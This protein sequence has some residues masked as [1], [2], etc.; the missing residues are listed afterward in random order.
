MGFIFRN[1]WKKMFYLFLFGTVSSVLLVLGVYIHFS[2]D[3]P[4][5]TG[6]ED[7]RP[8]QITKVYAEDGT[9]I[10]EFAKEK[11]IYTPISEIPKDVIAAYLAAED[12]SFYTHGGFDIKGIVR[13]ML[14]NIMT[15]KLQGASTITQQVAK[16]FLLSSERTYTRKIK[17]LILARRIESHFTKNQILELYLNQ[18]YLGNGTYGVAAA[19][20]GYFGKRLDEL[21]IGERAML[22]GLPKAP[23]S[24]NPY[25]RYERAI[26]RRNVVLMR[27][28]DENVITQEEY[29]TV[30][31]SDL[32]LAPRAG[33]SFPV[34]GF[35][36]EAVRRQV[37]DDFGT[38]ALYEKGY[39]VFTTLDPVLQKAAED[40]A[41]RGAV[42]Y[43]KRHGYQGPYQQMEEFEEEAA[44]ALIMKYEE[45]YKEYQA[46]GTFA[47]VTSVSDSVV[48]L[49]LGD[50]DIG[51][52]PFKDVEW[53]KE[54]T[55]MDENGELLEKPKLGAEPKSFAE[56]M[57]VGDLIAVKPSG[58]E[59]T[60]ALSFMP[61]VQ[62]ALVAIDPLTGA[63]R[64]LV[65]GFGDTKGFNRALQGKRQ[66]GSSFKPFVYGYAL[67]NGYTPAT[68]V[69]DAPVVVR[70]GEFGKA[71]KPQNYNKRFYGDTPLR[72][73]L[74]KS[75]NLM[76]IR[77]AQDLG[78]RRIIRFAESFGLDGDFQP[79]LSTALGSG[80][81]SLASL[82]SAYAS[83]V[84]GG[85]IVKPYMVE[86]VMSGHGQTLQSHDSLCRNCSDVT[87]IPEPFHEKV[88]V[89]PAT[90]AYQTANMLRGVVERG[91]ARRAKKLPGFV[92]GKTG[93]TNDY[94]DA[95]FMGF[96]P[97]LAVGVWIGFDNP[98]TLGHGE[99]GSR[100][101]LPI[102]VDFMGQALTHVERREMVVPKGIS[103][104]RIDADTGERPTALSERTIMEAFVPGTEPELK[105]IPNTFGGTAEPVED[106]EDLGI[107]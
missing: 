106:F 7:Y 49:Y 58:P 87:D 67:M 22:A 31:A 83:F 96:S 68:T 100:A 101:A 78:I 42:D 11:R 90:A 102:W 50:G 9:L 66:V 37:E 5:F 64:A 44:D 26:S 52:M 57:T 98:V 29:E 84:N 81:V 8:L 86:R 39:S 73:G 93:T 95:W 34:G 74:E 56:F 62:V 35:Y 104:V 89:M 1:F 6:L 92:G 21:D 71:W 54:V 18:I 61:K 46:F 30:K 28:L 2:K 75:R 20:K 12:T 14:V 4:D 19:A 33:S 24:Y 76:T 82:T 25:R 103:F 85:F 13:A 107:Y 97:E 36:R 23:S 32:N 40:A 43:H 77:L 94:I 10:D 53:A 69:L 3:L 80:N 51:F 88:Q 48:E 55:T 60:Y 47:V 16:T 105:T 91:T 38:D 70:E 15:N 65:G 17:E 45:K 27:M 41:M 63:I 79:D 59:G 72:V 99:S